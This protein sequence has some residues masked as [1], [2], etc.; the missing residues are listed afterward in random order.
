[1]CVGGG[2]GI[3]YDYIYV[4]VILLFVHES[5]RHNNNNII[6]PGLV[7]KQCSSV[8]WGTFTESI[9]KTITYVKYKLL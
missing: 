5:C 9:D 3:F 4:M 8:L 2:R 7:I 6:M 1:M